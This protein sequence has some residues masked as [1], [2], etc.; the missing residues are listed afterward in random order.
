MACGVGGVVVVVAGLRVPKSM[1]TFHF[2]VSQ[3]RNNN[4]SNNDKFTYQSSWYGL[5]CYYGTGT[6]SAA[7]IIYTCTY[8]RAFYLYEKIK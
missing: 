2:T 8:R 1:F 6:V 7:Q 5:Q 4:S 3:Y